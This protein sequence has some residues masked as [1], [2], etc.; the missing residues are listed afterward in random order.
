MVSEAAEDKVRIVV[1][2]FLEGD[3]DMLLDLGLD[4]AE[5][6]I[7]ELIVIVQMMRR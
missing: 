1:S 5:V 6:L 3:F 4:F 2:F 7:F